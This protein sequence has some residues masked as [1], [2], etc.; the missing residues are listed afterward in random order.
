MF[1]IDSLEIE[2][3]HQ[4][5]YISNKYNIFNKK[6]SSL[7]KIQKNFYQFRQKIIIK[8]FAI[9]NNLSNK[10]YT[11]FSEK[12]ELLNYINSGSSGI[13]YKGFNK[14]NPNHFMCFKFLLN[15]NRKN[16]KNKYKKSLLKEIII[17]NKLKNDKIIEY[18]NY[19]NLRNTGCIVMEYAELGDLDYFR[20][21]VNKKRYFSESLLA[22]I[23]LQILQGL[24]YLN[25]CKIIHMDIKEQNLLIDKNLNVKITDFSASFSYDNFSNDTKIL[26]PFAGT[27]FYMSPEVMSN[28]YID[29]KNCNKI[30]LYS[31]GIVLY[32]L[33]FEQFPFELNRSDCQNFE[34]ILRNKKRSRLNI[35]DNKLYSSMFKNFLIKLLE[36]NINNRISIYEALEDSWIKGAEILFE[37]KENINDSEIFLINL[38]T[39][40]VRN[41][42]EYINTKK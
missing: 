17:H 8:K 12:F 34:L 10:K 2:K 39:D 9:L 31:L 7:V 26:L 16:K 3:V 18:Y 23:A 30:D 11:N 25:K 35:P 42:N 41:F 1:S 37:E 15:N 5:S 24:Y 27:C 14:K 22:F 13:V 28:D 33:A 29:Y 4:I 32:S 6:T 40:N 20:K 36:P 19:I 21:I 38:I